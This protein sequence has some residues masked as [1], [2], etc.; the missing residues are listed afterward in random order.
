MAS[1][2][3]AREAA[4]PRSRQSGACAVGAHAAQPLTATV[5]ERIGGRIVV[6]PT[7][8]L[9]GLYG[10]TRAALARQASATAD[11]RDWRGY[12]LGH[13]QRLAALH[14]GVARCWS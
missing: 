5:A 3:F 11:E 6:V 12:V 10:V 8:P 13:V 9:G 14:C 1:S 4:R 7:T 2:F